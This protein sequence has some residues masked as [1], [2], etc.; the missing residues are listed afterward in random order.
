MEAVTKP[1]N[2]SHLEVA[3]GPL[4]DQLNQKC[5][6]KQDWVEV[7]SKDK[8]ISEIIHLFKTKELYC[9]KVNETDNNERRQ[10]IRQGNRLFMR[11]G[12]LYCK[13]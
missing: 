8:T 2:S 10:F 12:I 6:T 1:D 11:N 4:K 3:T 7:Q 13:K 9:R 5:M